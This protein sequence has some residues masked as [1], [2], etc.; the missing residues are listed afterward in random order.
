MK[1]AIKTLFIAGMVMLA[2]TACKKGKPSCQRIDY[3]MDGV[4]VTI[5]QW[6]TQEEAEATFGNYQNVKI[7]QFNEAEVD[8]LTH[9]FDK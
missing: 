4:A 8:C 3:T 5:Y 9:N 6:M 2:M 7:T 1:R